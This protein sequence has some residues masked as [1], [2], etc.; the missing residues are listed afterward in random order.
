MRLAGILNQQM[1]SVRNNDAP[2]IKIG[3]YDMRM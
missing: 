3:Y 1:I 2:L